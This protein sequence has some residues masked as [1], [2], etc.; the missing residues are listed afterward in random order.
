MLFVKINR[1]DRLDVSFLKGNPLSINQLA[2]AYKHE[3]VEGALCLLDRSA[4]S[5]KH[6]N[7]GIAAILP[8]GAPVE[9]ASAASVSDCSFASRVDPSVSVAGSGFFS[10][11]APALVSVVI[12][13]GKGL[14]VQS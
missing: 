11:R 5:P 13:L 6:A 9:G 14:V 2:N 1:P 7:A 3:G 8:A 4:F 10:G 12:D